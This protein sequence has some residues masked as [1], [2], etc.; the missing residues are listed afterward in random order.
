[1][2]ARMHK[3]HVCT[4]VRN[5]KPNLLY[6]L[7]QNAFVAVKTSNRITERRNIS[8]CIMQGTV[9]GGGRFCTTTRDKLGKFKYD[10]PEN[11]FKFKDIVDVPSLEMVDNIIDIQK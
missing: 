6:L 2:G 1:M 7:N 8:N 4:G 9:L 5:D 3:R 10:N 11:V